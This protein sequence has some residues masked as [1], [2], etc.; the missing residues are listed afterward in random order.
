[1]EYEKIKKLMDD[2]GESKLTSLSIDF[3]DGT[4]ITMSK[5]DENVRVAIDEKDEKQV[6]ENETEET[7]EVKEQVEGEIIKSPMVGTFYSKPSPTA[8]PYVEVGSMVKKGDT[9]CIVEAMKLMNEIESEFSGAITEVLV[10]D[11]DAVEYGTPLF[12]VKV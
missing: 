6:K 8:D 3:P 10:K 12:R 4:K 1:M 7:R 9:V 2:M 5:Q 11:G